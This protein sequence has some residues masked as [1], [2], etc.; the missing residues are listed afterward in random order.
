M[1]TASTPDVRAV[2][3]LSRHFDAT[4]SA[5]GLLSFTLAELAPVRGKKRIRAGHVLW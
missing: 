2:T 3:E 5:I 4:R 1:A